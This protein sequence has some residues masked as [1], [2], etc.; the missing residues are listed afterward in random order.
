[1]KLS[2]STLLTVLFVGLKLANYIN[3]SWVWV[4]SPLW[5]SAILYIFFIVLFFGSA[6][7]ISFFK[8]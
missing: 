3:W 1:M 8:K 2:L 7:L 6:V 4:L 5:I